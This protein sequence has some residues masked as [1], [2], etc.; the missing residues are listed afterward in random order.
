MD[1]Y[2]RAYHFVGDT[3]RDGRPVPA[4]G[5]WLTHDG[6]CVICE[7]GLHASRDPLDA[8]QYAPGSI[9]CLV[10][11][12]QI[13][14]E[15]NDKFVCRKRRIVARFDATTML[16]E[17]ARK[18]ALDVLHLW[19]APPVVR[20]YLETGGEDIRAAARAAAWDAAWDAAWAAAMDAAMAAQR[21][22]F[23]SLVDAEFAKVMETV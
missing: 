23:K 14:G 21:N 19:D 4:N 16:R 1:K 17:F 7:S 22:H 11:C 20:E 15:Q 18:C 6:D 13:E 12:G 8:L 2:A 9:L 3:L 10:D 5:E